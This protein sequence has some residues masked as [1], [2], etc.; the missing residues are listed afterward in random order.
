MILSLT[1]TSRDHI[2]VLRHVRGKKKRDHVAISIAVALRFGISM[3]QHREADHG[4]Y[5]RRLVLDMCVCL[6]IPVRNAT[7]TSRPAAIKAIS[8]SK[9]LALSVQPKNVHSKY[10]TNFFF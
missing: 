5:R 1:S 6:R 10:S 3:V 4:T 9:F 2:A 7:N 8:G